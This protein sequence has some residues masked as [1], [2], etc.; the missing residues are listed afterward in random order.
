MADNDKA[1]LYRKV[2]Q[3]SDEH[4]LLERMRLHGFWP[5]SQPLPQEPPAEVAER[6]RIEAELAELRKAHSVTR[7]PEKALA[8]ERKRRW[9]ESKK[10]RAEAKAQR[11]A[12]QQKRRETWD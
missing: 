7:Q 12:E 6:A 8:L 5:E 4:T 3:E 10:R 1:R 9:A 2:I 11:A